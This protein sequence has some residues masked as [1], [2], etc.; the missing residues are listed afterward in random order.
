MADFTVSIPDGPQ[1]QQVVQVLQQLLQKVG[2]SI[3]PAGQNGPM[4]PGARA[5]RPANLVPPQPTAPAP[6]APAP[7]PPPGP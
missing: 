5:N 2:G 3:T 4:P 6:M 7:P 1:A